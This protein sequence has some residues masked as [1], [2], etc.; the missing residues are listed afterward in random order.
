MLQATYHRVAKRRRTR[1]QRMKAGMATATSTLPDEFVDRLH[2][3]ARG[4]I[5]YLDFVCAIGDLIVAR[6]GRIDETDP[7]TQIA[8]KMLS[9]LQSSTRSSKKALTH[10]RGASA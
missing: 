10:T 1:K 7:S 2:R 9:I 5:G 3:R 6:R 4:T 8:K